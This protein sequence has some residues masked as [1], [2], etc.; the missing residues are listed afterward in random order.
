MLIFLHMPKT[1][2]HAF[3][4]LIE[5]R[6]GVNQMFFINGSDDLERCLKEYQP[7]KWSCLH[8]HM[9]YGISTCLREPCSY[10]V[11]LREPVDRFIS[12]YY[13]LYNTPKHPAHEQ[14]RKERL[15]LA[16]YARIPCPVHFV[17]HNA[18]VRRLC[19]YD[20][21]Q[22]TGDNKFW[23]LTREGVDGVM[24]EEAKYNLSR[25]I[26]LFGLYERFDESY[27][28]LGA[29]IGL[30]ETLAPRVNVSPF[31]KAVA[32]ID[33]GTLDAIREANR[34]DIALYEFA[35]E[36]WLERSTTAGSGS[37]E[38]LTMHSA[39]ASTI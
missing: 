27:Q 7:G 20:V 24:L 25:R 35:K 2:G 10:Y 28:Q 34:F 29:L 5:R 19:C 17:C 39:P 23:W 8:G 37:S 4:H 30:K 11:S 9:P 14:V 21:R 15:S 12:D 33:S 3:R 32:D 16:D 26:K 22:K 13:H 6:F 38:S 1:G 18:Q 31:R 36:L